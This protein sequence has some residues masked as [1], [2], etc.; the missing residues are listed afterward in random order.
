MLVLVRR[1]RAPG[2]LSPTVRIDIITHYWPPIAAPG[3]TRM[4]GWAETW[5]DAGHEIRVWTPTP[6]CGDPFFDDKRQPPG[7]ISTVHVPLFDLG[8]HWRRR[9]TDAPQ[10]PTRQPSPTRRF[11]LAVRDLLEIPDHRRLWNPRLRRAM[12]AA[13]PADVLVTTSPYNSTHLVGLDWRLRHPRGLWVA[14][15]RDPWTQPWRRHFSTP[16]HR[17]LALHH[18]RAVARHADLLTFWDTAGIVD[19]EERI[20]SPIAEKALGVWNGL[21]HDTVQELARWAVAPPRQP[22]RI[23]YAGTL[24]DWRLPP[25]LSAAWRAFASAYGRPAELCFVGRVEPGAGAALEACRRQAPADAPIRILPPVTAGEALRLQS[26]ATALLNLASPTPDT[27]TSKLFEMIAL[28]RPILFVGHP[29]SPGA[30][31]LRDLGAERS[32]AAGW[33]ADAI[34]HLFSAFGAALAKGDLTGW[35]PR[36]VPAEIDRAIQAERVL[37]RIAALA[38]EN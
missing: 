26:E 24:W 8:S 16:F 1:R 10:T 34:A 14:D 38:A 30:A 35:Q 22:P 33:D 4:L 31:W 12:R 37:A 20:G 15:F 9:P 13:T 7:G 3:T 19:M 27:L 17:R 29:D 25:G 32:I 21:A 11:A 6:D 28:Q 2:I 5:R 18:E 36:R 23:I